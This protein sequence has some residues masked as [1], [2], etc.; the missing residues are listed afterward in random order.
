MSK[1]PKNWLEEVWEIKEEIAK[2]TEGMKFKDYWA[3]INELA[4][5]GEKELQIIR[6]H[7]GLRTK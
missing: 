4:E 1:K 3:Y 7:Q 5:K 6:E 2:E